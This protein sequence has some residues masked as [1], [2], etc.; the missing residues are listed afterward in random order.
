[1]PVTLGRSEEIVAAWRSG[2]ATIEDNPAGPLLTGEYAESEI[3][4]ALMDT[5]KRASAC[6]AG[7]TGLCC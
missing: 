1:M 3:T 2:T 5:T 7:R 4:M 6:T